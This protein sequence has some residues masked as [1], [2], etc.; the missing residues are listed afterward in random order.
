MQEKISHKKALLTQGKRAHKTRIPEEPLEP[1]EPFEIP[2]GWVWTA[3]KNVGSTTTG[4]T[5]ST[6]NKTFFGGQIPFIGPG[7]IASSGIIVAPDKYLS[8]EGIKE[9]EE[10]T[11]DD[12]LMVC[13]GG[14]IGKTAKATE[15]C[16]FN[17]QINKIRPIIANADYL[18]AVLNTD[19]F[20]GRVAV[21]HG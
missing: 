20:L 5:P 17:Q 6:K 7:Q 4:K 13:I 14:S 16:G 3:L 8:E 12:L 15:R 18:L 2:R 9:S 11:P 10:A 21:S 1:N 19:F